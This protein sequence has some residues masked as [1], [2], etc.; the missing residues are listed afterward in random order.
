MSERV[1]CQPG[2]QGSSGKEGNVAQADQTGPVS[3][4]GIDTPSFHGT[5]TLCGL[6]VCPP[7]L[8]ALALQDTALALQVQHWHWGS[9]MSLIRWLD[10]HQPTAKIHESPCT[11]LPTR[12]YLQ[13]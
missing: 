6:T 1:L 12:E 8:P 13:A 4:V 9:L 5:S 10:A 11:V 3:L 7:S 2:S